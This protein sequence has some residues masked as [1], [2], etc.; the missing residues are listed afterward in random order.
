M[1][2]YKVDKM[3][4]VA[5]FKDLILRAKIHRQ[6]ND[7][8]KLQR[9]LDNANYLFTAWDGDQVV[10]YTRGL[11]DYADAVYVADLAVDEHYRYQGIGRHLLELVDQEVGHSIH[12]VLFASELAKD[13][14]A[15][16][17]YTKDPRGY[18]KNPVHLDPDD[19]TV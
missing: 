11:T 19:W 17:G 4:D 6:T 7:D 12:S 10:G 9:M 8:A 3:L 13:F 1:I 18:V 2:E 14:Y 5:T 15:K 16:I